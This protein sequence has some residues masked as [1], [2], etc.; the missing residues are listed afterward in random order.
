VTVTEENGHNL[1][2]WRC[3]PE[4]L[5]FE[6]RALNDDAHLYVR[7]A[8]RQ[9]DLARAAP[10]QRVHDA[11]AEAHGLT[12]AAR[13]LNRA[14]VELYL[15]ALPP[16]PEVTADGRCCELVVSA[17]GKAEVSFAKPEAVPFASR[18]ERTGT[19]YTVWFATP[20]ASLLKDSARPRPDYDL[21]NFF[22][23]PRK[24]IPLSSSVTPVRPG[25]VIGVNLS[26]NAPHIENGVQTKRKL[27]WQ[28]RTHCPFNDP[29]QWGRLRLA[30]QGEA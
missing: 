10:A 8:V 22:G 19:G 9:R 11:F 20:F 12:D 27:W 3:E 16:S 21:L 15:D 29:Q 23:L 2:V 28:A 1:L 18:A 7:V 30:R 6:I 14:S 25:D 26:V 24:D 13:M 5:S 17:E 4:E